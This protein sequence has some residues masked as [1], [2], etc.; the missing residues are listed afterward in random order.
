MRTDLG[1]PIGSRH[2]VRPRHDH[3]AAKLIDGIEDAIIVGCHDHIGGASR[4]ASPL[5]DVLNEILPGFAK[6]RLTGEPR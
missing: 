1:N 5:V 4:L 2:V 6:E 3:P